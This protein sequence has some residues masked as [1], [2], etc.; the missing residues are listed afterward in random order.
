MSG[1]A[2]A[3][4]EA[5]SIC[6][7]EDAPPRVWPRALGPL[8]RSLSSV[9]AQTVGAIAG[10]GQFVRSRRSANLPEMR[11]L[12]T[13]DAHFG[14]LSRP[15]QGPPQD[16]LFVP[17]ES[18]VNAIRQL[19][20]A[21]I[22]GDGIAVLTA[23][24]GLGKTV[25]CR[26]VQSRLDGEL[27]TVLL[28]SSNFPTRR[29]LLQ[30]ILHGLDRAYS[31]LTEQEM[32]L[33]VLDACKSILPERAGLVIIADEAHLLGARLLEELRCLTN[34]VERGQPL[35][36]VLLSGQLALEEMLTRPDLQ[37]LNYRITCHATL[38]P[39]T[40]R[41]SARYL[42]ER[43][44]RVGG[45]ASSLF[46]TAALE[47]ICR[48]S[49]GNP[50]CLNQIADACLSRAAETESQCVTEAIVRS[51][52][53]DLRQLPFQWNESACDQLIDTEDA[54][55]GPA[56]TDLTFGDGGSIVE[57]GRMHCVSTSGSRNNG[58]RLLHMSDSS[59]G[60]A[61]WSTS[62]ATIEV[63]AD[64]AD[65]AAAASGR[66]RES[67][68]VRSCASAS[69]AASDLLPAANPR[70]VVEPAAQ[71]TLDSGTTT[72][73]SRAFGREFQE[74][75]V[76]DLYAALDRQIESTIEL[77]PVDLPASA[78]R[79][80]QDIRGT[81]HP[82]ETSPLDA[83]DLPMAAQSPEQNIDRVIRAVSDAVAHEIAREQADPDDAALCEQ[84]G[85]SVTTP[86]DRCV[87]R[88]TPEPSLYDVVEPM[89]PGDPPNEIPRSWSESS[90][91]VLP[92]VTAT[93]PAKPSK[94]QTDP[95]AVSQPQAEIRTAAD[96]DVRQCGRMDRPYARLFSRA[97]RHKVH[98]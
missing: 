23:A 95:H 24:A 20:E 67:R 82:R 80:L 91:P 97:R 76:E 79:G 21:V 94:S 4:K 5:D 55:G 30:A 43:L 3:R 81:S 96:D 93:G 11:P 15:F 32:R 61:S 25:V 37:S 2:Q 6:C 70:N 86:T 8:L 7:F 65:T 19:S 60:S 92:Q 89:P 54:E 73:P 22:K 39:L 42:D 64:D 69:G 98:R 85:H 90:I 26:Q 33:M 12:M 18:A 56:L 58:S 74:L 49:D 72:A 16:E 47:M 27:A 10:S 46:S 40:M 13:Y 41:E 28:A 48:I 63:G 66:S 87:W 14:F 31:G 59:A 29:S 78:V 50:R 34:H 53:S 83:L 51:V 71:A 36:R 1:S 44:S 62:V 35:I 75:P 52:L 88:A 84:V 38:E 57:S 45:N 17:L 9:A 68:P 77:E